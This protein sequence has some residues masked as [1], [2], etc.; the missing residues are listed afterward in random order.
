MKKRILIVSILVA[1]ALIFLSAINTA[2]NS[3]IVEPVESIEF[4]EPEIEF[5]P[6]MAEPMNQFVEEPI[7]LEDWMCK[8]FIIN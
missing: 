2:E 4:V 5:E 3:V 7:E 1:I 6:W 8:P